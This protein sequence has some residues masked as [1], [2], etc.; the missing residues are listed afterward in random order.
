MPGLP[1]AS[2]PILHRSLG[3]GMTGIAV[4]FT[5]IMAVGVGP[6][7]REPD[8]GGSLIGYV[9]TGISLV[10]AAFA[11]LLMKRRVP[12]R[13]PGQS[14][15]DFWSNT[16]VLN[17]ILV[18]WFALTGAGTLSAIAFLLSGLP[19]AAIVTAFVIAMFWMNGPGA[20]GK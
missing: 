10:E 8:G 14:P 1:A 11:L 17:K 19:A 9:M 2:L 13:R 18:V 3:M 12:E 20:F 15:Q 16:D 7:L 5:G 4:V 6:L